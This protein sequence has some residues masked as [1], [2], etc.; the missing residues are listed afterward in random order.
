MSDHYPP[1]VSDAD[2]EVDPDVCPECG[3]PNEHNEC[4]SGYCEDH[5]SVC[6]EPDW[7]DIVLARAEARAED[8]L[9][10]EEP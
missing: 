5:C 7:A 10:Q 6:W 2:F 9:S 3:E 8:T 1:G 4:L